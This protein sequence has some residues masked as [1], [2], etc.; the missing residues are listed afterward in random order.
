MTWKWRTCIL[1]ILM[2]AHKIGL[3]K[4]STGQDNGDTVKEEPPIAANG[5]L[6][7]ATLSPF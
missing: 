7:T 3:E 4:V 1:E 6:W 2:Q 5:S